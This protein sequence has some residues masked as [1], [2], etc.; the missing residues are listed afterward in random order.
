MGN[1]KVLITGALGQIGRVLTK[2]LSERYGIEN[3]IVSDIN[4]DESVQND[5]EFL[6]VTDREGLQ[7]I[8][9]EKKINQ[10]YHLAALLSASGERNIDRTWRINFDGFI[11][12]LEVARECDVERIFYP[13][14]IAVFGT[15]FETNNTP[16][17]A[18]R[19]PSTMYGISK[20]AGESW[21]QY[22][23]NKYSLDVR[24]I[25]YPGI[26]G[27][28]SMP[29]G[30]TTDYAVDIFHQALSKGEYTCFLAP[31]TRLPMIYMDDAIRATL[32]LMEA[33]IE[34]IRNRNSYNLQ[35]LSFSPEELA[36]EITKHLP[37]FT[38]KYEPDE[39]QLIAETWPRSMDD[40]AART[41]WNWS[42][43][44][45]LE[46]LVGDMIKHLSPIYN[47][48]IELDVKSY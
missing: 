11:N 4:K 29:G 7:R 10:I 21:S 39:R 9:K 8:V 23:W 2:A 5:F 30:G 14:S 44:Y 32:E 42:E 6:D 27:H 26:I 33:P 12:V 45:N 31:H 17:N 47:Q 22:Y 36:A 35:G 24:S 20:L 1:P 43:R 16:Q 48:D 41:D 46:L 25:R 28:S 19:N 38:V 40:N 34:N 37:N 3:I 18:Y 13:S 15:D